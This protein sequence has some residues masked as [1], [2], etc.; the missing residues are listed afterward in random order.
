MHDA[1]AALV[2]H[3]ARLLLLRLQ[4]EATLNIICVCLPSARGSPAGCDDVAQEFLFLDIWAWAELV[5]FR[6]AYDC[7]L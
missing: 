2:E 5:A 1:L 7:A 6:R 4:L 3:R